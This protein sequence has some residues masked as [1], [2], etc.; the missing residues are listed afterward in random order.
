MTRLVCPFPLSCLLFRPQV[1]NVSIIRSFS[2]TGDVS[3]TR[4]LLKAA[5]FQ[6]VQ[7]YIRQEYPTAFRIIPMEKKE[8]SS[9]SLSASWSSNSNE[10]LDTSP[11][12]TLAQLNGYT[13]L[14]IPSSQRVVF[15]AE[16]VLARPRQRMFRSGTYTLMAKREATKMN[17]VRHDKVHKFPPMIQPDITAYRIIENKA[18][19][20]LYDCRQSI[21]DN[22]QKYIIHPFERIT[23]T[24]L[25]LLPSNSESNDESATMD[26]TCLRIHHETGDLQIITH[27]QPRHATLLTPFELDHKPASTLITVGLVVFGA[28]PLAYRSWNF[29]SA[30]PA[31]SRVIMAS[32]IGTVAYGIWSSRSEA[33]TNQA[34]AVTRAIMP[35]ILAQNE[36]AWLVLQEG[37]TE[38]LVDYLLAVY[39]GVSSDEWDPATRQ[40]VIKLA[41]EWGFAPEKGRASVSAKE[42]LKNLE[43]LTPVH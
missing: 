29:M 20:I 8:R 36:A 33:R 26:V 10:R 13:S 2:S 28:V 38:R 43:K 5:L 4:R 27:V 39:D 30:Y 35:R 41:S 37:A 6:T 19:T 42:V 17:N 32:V 14:E 34:L 22:L 31:M 7:Q 3:E 16:G 24:S 21:L 9:L 12:T 18:E 15:L 23:G 40:V 11:A 1:W 25:A